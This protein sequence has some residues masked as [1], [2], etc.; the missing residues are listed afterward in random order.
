MTGTENQAEGRLIAGRYRLERR[1]GGGAMGVVWLA[2]DELLDRTVALKHLLLTAGLSAEEAEHAR[3]RSSREARIAARLQHRHAITVFDVADDDGMPVLVMEYLPSQSLAEVLTAR[4]PLPP[5]EVARIGA[6]AASALAEAHAAGIVHRD[7]K[8]G[9]ILLGEDGTAKITDFGISRATDDGTLT[10]SGA[11]AGTPAFLS[12]EAARGERPT[13]ASDVFSLGATLYAIVEGR[14]PY[15]DSDNQMALLYSAAAG[16]VNPPQQAGPLTAVLD[17]MMRV[18]P[19]ERPTMAEVATELEK[20]AS[21]TPEE[22][23]RS[24][25]LVWAG[26]GA[27]V[28]VAAVVTTLLLVNN[29]SGG[30]NASPPAS[31]AQQPAPSSQQQAPPPTTGRTTSSSSSAPPSSTSHPST[32]AATT[33]DPVQFMRDYYAAMPGGISAGWA[34]LSPAM[35][36]Q[37]GYPYYQRYWSEMSSFQVVSGPQLVGANTVESTLDFVQ[38][39]QHFRER[40]RV[41][42]IESDGRL[43]VNS[44]SS[45][46]A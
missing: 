39:G 14:F 38:R 12:P 46:N 9:N 11:F 23:R 33:T 25:A 2:K 26:A 42:L 16:R 3:K 5:E 32:S 22:R 7:V 31:S 24:R 28:L 27:V 29:G 10:G 41:T 40:H 30:Q 43:L 45:S 44:D 19:E 37:V 20:L 34:K 18:D 17:R 15:G 13:A 6:H 4:G 21:P 35:Q 36:G 1:I 8:P